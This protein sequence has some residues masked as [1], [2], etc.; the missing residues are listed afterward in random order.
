MVFD[1]FLLNHMICQPHE[2]Q[3][4]ILNASTLLVYPT[5]LCPLP[6]ALR[7][8]VLLSDIAFPQEWRRQ[9]LTG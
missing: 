1:A 8:T 3:G 6:F 4:Q 5:N 2:K 7:R 9:R